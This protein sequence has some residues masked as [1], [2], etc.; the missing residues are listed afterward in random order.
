MRHIALTLC[1]LVQLVSETG[2]LPI[3]RFAL[4]PLQVTLDRIQTV[5]THLELSVQL[6]IWCSSLEMYVLA[7]TCHPSRLLRISQRAHNNGPQ[8]L[9]LHNSTHSPFRLVHKGRETVLEAVSR[10]KRHSTMIS[11]SIFLSISLSSPLSF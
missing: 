11:L 3:S 5:I 8:L 7:Y 1:S 9:R 2:S 4:W 10:V 6:I